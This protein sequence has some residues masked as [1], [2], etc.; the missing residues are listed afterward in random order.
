M[1][2]SHILTADRVACGVEAGSKKKALEQLSGLLAKA[3]PDLVPTDIFDTLYRRETLGSTGLGRGVA[4]PHGRLEPLDRTVG[5]FVRTAGGI[6]FDAA[7]GEPVDLLFALLVPAQ[8]TDEHLRILS[9]LAERFR[10]ADLRE[11]LR[12]A[13]H[14][15]DLFGLLTTQAP[16]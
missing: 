8:A 7:D 6:D 5:A 16:H 10:D 4:L 11:R 12:E 3:S 14:A 1:E 15:G 9:R 13:E 2:I